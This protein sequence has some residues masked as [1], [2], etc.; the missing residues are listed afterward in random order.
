M[1]R[2]STRSTVVL[3]FC[4]SVFVVHKQGIPALGCYLAAEQPWGFF[5]CKYVRQDQ[6]PAGSEEA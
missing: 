2:P 1:L 3:Q 6:G 5:V 4:C